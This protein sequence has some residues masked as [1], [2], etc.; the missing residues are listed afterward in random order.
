MHAHINP[1]TQASSRPSTGSSRLVSTVDGLPCSSRPGSSS[2]S[3]G[4]N[5]RASKHLPPLQK[6]PSLHRAYLA[7]PLPQVEMS[8]E[9]P[10]QVVACAPIQQPVQQQHNQAI[11]GHTHQ[12]HRTHRR[13]S[14]TPLRQDIPPT[15]PL[16]AHP[17]HTRSHQ[18]SSAHTDQLQTC[19]RQLLPQQFVSVPLNYSRPLDPEQQRDNQPL[20]LRGQELLDS[21]EADLRYVVCGMCYTVTWICCMVVQGNIFAIM[22]LFMTTPPPPDGWDVSLLSLNVRTT[23]KIFT[24]ESKQADLVTRYLSGSF[25]IAKMGCSA[26]LSLSQCFCSA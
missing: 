19:A 8:A 13:L 18:Q 11:E 23:T 15:D 5:Y 12:P 17:E 26:F 1:H 9:A 6:L 2:S 7:A 22:A 3:S 16:P 20:P 25:P 4:G 24:S 14:L 10:S 21:L